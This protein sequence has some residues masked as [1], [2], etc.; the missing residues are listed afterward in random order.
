LCS[1]QYNKRIRINILSI[2]AKTQTT[3][4]IWSGLMTDRTILQ[5]IFMFS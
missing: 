2:T 1:K 5:L 4:K 3:D